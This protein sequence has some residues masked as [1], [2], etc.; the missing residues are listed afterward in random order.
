LRTDHIERNKSLL[1]S[2][3]VYQPLIDSILAVEK[4]NKNIIEKLGRDKQ[5][6]HSFFFKV[7]TDKELIMSW[8]YEILPLLEEYYYCDYNDILATLDISA[9]N[10]YLNRDKGILGFKNINE[11]NDFL[12]LILKKTGA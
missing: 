9:E 4:I 11:L 8:Q 12:A 7:F 1:E 2:Q 5:I 3:N 6:G 10:P